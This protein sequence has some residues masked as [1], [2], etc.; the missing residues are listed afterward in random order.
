MTRVRFNVDLLDPEDPFEIDDGN[1]PHLFKHLPTDV[2]GRYVQ[3]GVEDIYDL[4]L[5]GDPTFY[6]ADEE[7]EADWLMVGYVPG[8]TWLGV[9]LALPNSGNY[10]KCRPIG[11]YHKPSIGVSGD[12]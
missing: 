1:R 3:V 11:I 12:E 7:G 5:F 4:Y 9:P 2:A 6:E 8:L 10:R